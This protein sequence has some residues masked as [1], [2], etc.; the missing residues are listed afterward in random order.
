MLNKNQICMQV[1]S[2]QDLL[3]GRSLRRP[4]VLRATLALALIGVAGRAD[5]IYTNFDAANSNT[6][7]PAI[8]IAAGSGG[9]T[10]A[11]S[12]TPTQDYILGSVTLALSVPATETGAT[13]TV[14]IMN[15][16]GS[17]S[18]GTVIE[19]FTVTSP[20]ASQTP[21]IPIVLNSVLNPTLSAYTQY[22]LAVA[23][24]DPNLGYWQTNTT[25]DLAG[26]SPAVLT[27]VSSAGL[28]GP[29]DTSFWFGEPRGA[30]TISGNPATGP[31]DPAITS[32]VPATIAVGSPAFTLTVNGVRF[33]TGATVQ[34]NGASLV[35]TVVSDAQLTAAVPA[36]LVAS[37]GVASVAVKNPSGALSNTVNFTITA[38][39]Q[40]TI[41]SL[42]PSSAVAGGAAFTLTIAGSNFVTGATVHFGTTTLTPTSIT[43]TQ[44]QVT[45]PATLIATPGAPSVTVVESSATSNSLSFTIASSAVTISSLIPSSVVAGGPDM[46]MVINGA[47][48][49]SGAT[50]VFGGVTLT[51]VVV[52]PNQILV[53]VPAA[54]V[55]TIGTPSVFVT[56]A[57]GTSNLMTFVVGLA[58]GQ[59]LAVATSTLLP[60]GKVG[61]AY[62][63]AVIGTGGA[64]PYSYAL[65]STSKLPAGLSLDATGAITGKPTATG[66]F[67]FSATVTDSASASAT[68]SFVLYIAPAAP[69]GT[70]STGAVLSPGTVGVAY[71][72]T[73]A[74]SGGTPPFVWTA[75]QGV[76]PAGLSLS[77]DGIISGTPTTAGTSVFTVQA[78]D[79]TQASASKVLSLEIDAGV[80][81]TLSAALSHFASGG[82]WDSSIYLINTS[83]SDVAVDVKFL[84][85]NGSPLTL[86]MSTAVGGATHT[87][88]ASEL[89]ETIPPG[90]TML[91]EVNSPGTAVGSSGWVQVVGTGPIKGYA[92]FHYS[93]TTGAESAATVPLE[94]A[95]APSFLL[96]YD[97]TGGLQTG[98]AL[99][100]LAATQSTVTATIMDENG[101]Q[102]GTGSVVLPASGHTSFMLADKFPATI[103]NRGIIRFSSGAATNIS[104]LGLRVYPMGGFASIPKLQ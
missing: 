42:T 2:N 4:G 18:P 95:F 44:I 28:V 52:I 88:S 84:A 32:L 8:P 6:A 37:T 33:L 99:A 103:A 100:N 24:A 76:L 67:S 5:I 101:N 102:I 43:A 48:F 92:A 68:G 86:D 13:F 3:H 98:V 41:S 55:A 71:S 87:L 74:A 15:D 51:P 20:P 10:V 60:A 49:T 50:V 82:G 9:R 69:A 104:G 39:P 1:G 35:T 56:E 53:N 80:A 54:S 11:Q 73:L 85:D 64:P 17:G 65:S 83:A 59:P 27:L 7:S 96:P 12:F 47:G 93:S 79:S 77:S 36:S 63:G 90:A 34:W 81:A 66:Y 91:I 40:V 61:V 14:A 89:N 23:P 25:G 16:S 70:I 94:S 62:S 57:S 58:P 22:W 78:T 75:V 26:S 97:G 72:F 45:V 29:W 21:V 19:Q 30:F 46:S 38:L 31:S